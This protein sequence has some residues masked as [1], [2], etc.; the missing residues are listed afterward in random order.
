MYK[1]L[2]RVFEC[3]LSAYAVIFG[4]IFGLVLSAFTL[5]LPNDTIPA[6][7]S[8]FLQNNGFSAFMQTSCEQVI[9]TAAIFLTG[10]IPCTSLISSCVI[11]IRA[12]LASYS[13]LALAL[14]GASQ[15]LYV[16]HALSSAFILCICFAVARCAYRHSRSDAKNALSYTLEFLFFTGI[17]LILLFCRSIALAFV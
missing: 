4:Y 7:D 3:D 16:L 8:V 6:L 14:Q 15:P 2:L 13:C 17:M 1:K 11:F 9:Y 12:S 5:L 10:F